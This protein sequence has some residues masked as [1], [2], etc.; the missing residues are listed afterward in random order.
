MQTILNPKSELLPKKKSER[1][2]PCKQ[3]HLASR[4]VLIGPG[5]PTTPFLRSSRKKR[6]VG[7]GEDE[8]EEEDWR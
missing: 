6:R 3:S 2:W 8:Q 4:V 7:E 1:K 5:C